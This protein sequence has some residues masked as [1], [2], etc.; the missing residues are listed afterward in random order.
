MVKEYRKIYRKKNGDVYV[1]TPLG[2]VT[3]GIFEDRETIFIKTS[4]IEPMIKWTLL[5]AM[6]EELKYPTNDEY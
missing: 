1:V 5:E 6:Y 2:R 3:M 4:G